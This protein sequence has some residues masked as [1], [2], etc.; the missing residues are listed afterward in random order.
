[1]A[2]ILESTE[3]PARVIVE[4]YDPDHVVDLAGPADWVSGTS[5]PLERVA[6]CLPQ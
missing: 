6:V 2:A 1:V 3:L 4:T 5:I